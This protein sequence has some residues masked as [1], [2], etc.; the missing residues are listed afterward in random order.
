MNNFKAVDTIVKINFVKSNSDFDKFRKLMGE[1]AELS[2]L[3]KL[4]VKQN[5]SKIFYVKTNM[6]LLNC[7]LL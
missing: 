5:N 1:E 3:S 6:E 2:Y 4:I 7:A